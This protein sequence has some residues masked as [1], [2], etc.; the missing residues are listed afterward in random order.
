VALACLACLSAA[1]LVT[2]TVDYNTPNT[3]PQLMK[4]GNPGFRSVP[5]TP[6]P[7]CAVNGSEGTTPWLRFAVT[8]RDPDA[9]DDLFGR[10]IIN[11]VHAYTSTVKGTG[12][13]M[14]EP[15]EYCATKD[16]LYQKCLHVEILV[17]RNFSEFGGKDPYGTEDPL[18]VGYAEWW[19][20]GPTDDFPE[21]SVASCQNLGE[22]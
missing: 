16:E 1:C 4:V 10:V 20:V 6:E 5:T 18:D 9:D 7:T 12:N 15:F 3:P 11:G 14:R 8:V 2:S 13:V 21:V 22:P 19:L 17:T